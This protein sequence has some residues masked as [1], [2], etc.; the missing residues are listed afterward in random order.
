M[1]ASETISSR[2]ELHRGPGRGDNAFVTYLVFSQSQD[3]LID[4]AQLG[5]YASRFFA[6][7]IEVLGGT[8]AGDRPKEARISFRSKQGRFD[9]VFKITTR[10]VEREDLR[11][12][13]EAEARGNAQGMGALAERC[14]FVWEMEVPEGVSTGAV[15]LLCAVLASVALGPVL[16]PDRQTLFGVR[17]A[18][19]LAEGKDSYRD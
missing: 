18:R 10:R 17:G 4:F 15:H 13:R 3:G 19:A 14:K 1:C 6:A 2:G 7:E 5:N 9:A 16:P 8:P 12:A 11:A